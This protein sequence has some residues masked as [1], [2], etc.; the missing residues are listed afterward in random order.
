MARAGPLQFD[1]L[2]AI[3]GRRI[4]LLLIELA[5]PTRDPP[6][7]YGVESIATGPDKRDS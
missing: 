3:L 6:N 4:H 5:P 7:V 2:E 1:R